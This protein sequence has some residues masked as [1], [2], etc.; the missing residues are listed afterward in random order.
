MNIQTAIKK[1]Q[2]IL[3]DNN[4]LSAQL[5]SEILMIKAISKDKKYLILN[6]HKEI[7]KRDLCYFDFLI[8]ERVKSKPIAQIIKK[9]D[10]WKY[11]FV[12]NEDVLIPRPDT[13]V[14]VEQ[15]LELTKNKN[16]LKVLDIGTG[17]GCILIS[18]LKEKKNFIGTG[19]DISNKSLKISK[20]NSHKLG[21]NNRLRLLKSNID[22]FSRGKYDLIISNPPYI[23][24]NDL[25]CL[26]KDINFEPKQALDG[27]FDGLSEMSKVITKSSKL[28]KKNGY[29]ILEIGFDQKSRVIKILKNK[30]FYIKKI[31]K[32]LSNHDRCIVSIKI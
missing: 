1:G 7:K 6:L 15:V 8:S 28:I 23:K 14:L 26:E 10:F 16:K 5:D 11:E 18:I 20:V 13:E 25:K 22:N 2:S 9:K 31:V 19:I 29:L 12:V 3:R 30:G 27:G 17:S 21:V 24:K 32:D 4:I